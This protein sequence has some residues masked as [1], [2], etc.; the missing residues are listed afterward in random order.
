MAIDGTE[1]GSV[2]WW[3]NRLWRKLQ[4][5]QARFD[6][7]QAYYEGRPPLAWGSEQTKSRF[8]RFQ[9]TSRTNYAAMIVQARVERMGLRSVKTAASEDPDRDAVAWRLVTGN[10]LDITFPEAARMAQRFGRSYLAT[11]SPDDGEELAQ[12][13]A[14]DPRQVVIESDP[15]NPNKAKAAFKLFHDSEAGLDVAILWLPG[16]K[17]VAVKQRTA[18]TATRSL[19]S[20]GIVG[21]SDPV[22]VSFSLGSYDLRDTAPADG[23]EA[24]D[25]YWSETYDSQTVPVRELTNADGVG[26]Y[27][28]HLDLLDRLNHLNLMLM[29][30]T[31]M[32]AFRQRGIEQSADQGVGQLE[33]RDETGALIDYNDMFES[34]PDSLWLLPPGAKVWESGQAD[35][36]GLLQ[37][38]KQAQLTLSAVTRT[39]MTMFTPDAATQ[40]AEGAQLQREGLVFGVEEF[41]RMAGRVLAVNIALG[42]EYMGDTER[43]DPSKVE[44]VF[45]P[46]ERYS[47]SEMA[48]ASQQAATVLP[49]ESI[50][51]AVWQ[52]S[53]QQ[54]SA[55][56]S[57]RSEDLVLAAQRAA[58]AARSQPGAQQGGSG[59]AA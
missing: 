44:V 25:P 46:A 16:K 19:R 20:G 39:P 50:L 4:A 13:T 5:D 53:P 41:L 54:I 11:S 59:G 27:E 36:N 3:M 47:L 37:A 21:I 52:M 43:S 26:I 31:T 29:V 48:M 23:E 18:P 49:F 1:P 15:V 8:Y 40:T 35:L 17:H 55:A 7:L 38:I 12:I 34:G 51:E 22:K 2:G 9:Q 28:M 45:L 42:F 6:L 14:E 33:E 57:Q 30:I 24:S 10:N 56:K 58:L 32:Q